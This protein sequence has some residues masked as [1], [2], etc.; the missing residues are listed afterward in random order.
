[1]AVVLKSFFY[2]QMEIISIC[3]CVN[4]CQNWALQSWLQKKS[5]KLG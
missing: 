1:M 3:F 2:L 5:D 4:S